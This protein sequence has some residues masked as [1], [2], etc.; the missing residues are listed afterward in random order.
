MKTIELTDV[1][2][3][4][5]VRHLQAVIVDLIEQQSFLMSEQRN[6]ITESAI[7]AVAAEMSTVNATLA[8]LKEPLP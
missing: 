8:K 5:V 4:C 7:L 3:R 1:E 6:V 2:S